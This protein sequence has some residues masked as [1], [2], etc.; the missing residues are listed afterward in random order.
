MFGFSADRPM[1]SWLL[2]R[3]GPPPPSPRRHFSKSWDPDPQHWAAARLPGLA[4]GAGSRGTPPRN[5]PS[6]T[7]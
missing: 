7:R 6:D 5:G 4:L 3:L 1:F 2:H